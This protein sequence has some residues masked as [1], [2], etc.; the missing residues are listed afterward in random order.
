MLKQH[1]YGVTFGGP[2]RIPWIYNGKNKTFFFGS[3]EWFRNRAGSGTFVTSVPTSE[4]YQGDFSKWVDS[5]G[6]LLPI[7]DPATTRPN[8]NFNSGAPI[9][10]SNPRF[11]RDPFPGNIIQRRVQLA[12]AEISGLRR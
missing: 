11:I 7:Y 12:G 6:K 1:D 3:A 10:E 2:V 9:S 8:P 5:T 4:M